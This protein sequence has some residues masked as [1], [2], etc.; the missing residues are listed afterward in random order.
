MAETISITINNWEKFNGRKDIRHPTWFR[1]EYRLLE[2]PDFYDFTHE[3]FKAWLY[4][5]SNACRKNTGDIVVNFDHA[6]AVSRLS[7]KGIL[8]ALEKLEKLQLVHRDVTCTSRGRNA[9][10]T[11]PSRDSTV[12]DSTVQDS[13]DHFAQQVERLYQE[14]YP[15]KVGK[16]KG[17]KRLAREVKTPEDLAN[18]ERAIKNYAKDRAGNE[19]QYIQHFSSFAGEWKDWVDYAVTNETYIPPIKFNQAKV[20]EEEEEHE[21]TPEIIKIIK[22]ALSGKEL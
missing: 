9:D 18:L 19:A 22:S 12:Q 13:T 20:F 17:M 6:L 4:V 1:V 10:V 7:K 8:S 5:L 11:S 3:E 14:F 15:R 16:D 21:P 2:D